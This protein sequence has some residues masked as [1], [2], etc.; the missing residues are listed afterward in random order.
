MNG[1]GAVCIQAA[2]VRC[3]VSHCVIASRAAQ[4]MEGFVRLR[5]CVCV[6]VRARVRLS[7]SVSLSLCACVCVCVLWLR[8]MVEHKDERTAPCVEPSGNT[9]P[10]VCE[11]LRSAMAS[12]SLAVGGAH[13][14]AAN[15]AAPLDTCARTPAGSNARVGVRESK[16]GRGIFK[17][18][19]R[20]WRRRR[21][22]RR[23]SKSNRRRRRRRRR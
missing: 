1:K 22:R 20:A 21:G 10:G 5:A 19:K 2:C 15:A 3:Q 14:A 23:R 12:L 7:L 8:N 11:M 17:Q 6:C 9:M 16:A 18:N 13:V 4:A